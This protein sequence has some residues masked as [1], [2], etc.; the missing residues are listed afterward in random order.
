[1]DNEVELLIANA[2]RINPQFVEMTT[3][4]QYQWIHNNLD[5]ELIKE[6]LAHYYDSNFEYINKF[7]YKKF[8]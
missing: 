7:D 8:K 3:E 4:E 1:M 2:I 6:E 5:K